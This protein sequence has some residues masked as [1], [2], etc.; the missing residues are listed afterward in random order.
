MAQTSL[1]GRVLDAYHQ[2]YLENVSLYLVQNKLSLL[3]DSTGSFQ[4]QKLTKGL[5][6][7]LVV[8]IIGYKKRNIPILE[9]NFQHIHLQLD[10]PN[11]LA[12]VKVK[13]SVPMSE[14]FV[15]QKINFLDVVVNASS[16]AD[17]LLAV[18]STSAA[19]PFS[20][21]ASISFRG[22]NPQLTQI[23]IND[24]PIP[25]PIKF[26]QMSSL[27][28]FSL[29]PINTIKDLLIFPSNP[30]LELMN[31]S[32][33]VVQ[34]QSN[35]SF[36]KQ[37]LEIDVSLGQAGFHWTPWAKEKNGIGLFGHHQFSPLLKFF[38]PNSLSDLPHFSESDWGINGYF[39]TKNLWRLKLFSLFMTEKYASQFRHPSF[40]GTFDYQKYRHVQTINLSKLLEH[41]QWTFKFGFHESTQHDST[42]NYAYH[43]KAHQL[44]SGIDL[45]LFPHE[46][47]T[48]KTGYQWFQTQTQY[49]IRKP[50]YNFDYR[51]QSA[52]VSFSNNPCLSQ[53]ELFL[54]NNYTLSKP[55]RIGVGMK[56]THFPQLNDMQL[57]HQIHT[58]WYLNDS[59]TYTNL[60]WSK[61]IASLFTQE[62]DYIWVNTQQVSW[63]IVQEQEL[64]KWSFHAFYKSEKSL[65]STGQAWGAEINF[66]LIKSKSKH[67][68]GIGSHWSQL[69][70]GINTQNSPYQIPFFLRT[71]SQWKW[72]HFDL[73]MSSLFRIGN[74]FRTLSSSTYSTE[75]QMYIPQYEPTASKSLPP[76]MRIDAMLSKM[77]HKTNHGS[78][79]T[80]LSISNLLNH[81]N[82]KSINYSW[83]YQQ[84]FQEYFQKR[85]IYIGV[86][87]RW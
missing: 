15:N 45:Q 71:T 46:N 19:S 59:Y 44:F 61:Q 4:F 31:A 52:F 23:Y 30:P 27:G 22:S 1:K 74:Y 39:Q 9:N 7:T 29:I 12:E 70:T 6:D 35:E 3:S 38:N 66:S 83:D 69:K 62:N 76:Y 34:I 73:S 67:E 85:V 5:P 87:M 64:K 72:K 81:D 54:S 86:Q 21:S 25:E 33:G 8:S 51:P 78:W 20:E 37:N 60:A 32:T 17:P 50:Y 68:W 65:I 56:L 40:E 53:H 79:I 57:T 63:D 77:I 18:Q 2:I 26:T 47:W 49:Q 55:F 42:G 28:T 82:V 80:Y 14:D 11:A 43:P 48:I 84:S 41:A 10:K 58:R 16:K 36:K 75:L 24:I 13:A